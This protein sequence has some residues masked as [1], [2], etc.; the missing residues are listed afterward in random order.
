MDCTH[1]QIFN[2]DISKIT[3]LTY[4]YCSGNLNLTCIQALNSQVKTLWFK[5]ATAEYS[6]NCNYTVGINNETI[7]QPKTIQTI[8]NLQGQQ[9]NTA[10]QG[11]VIIRYTD[12][13]SEKVIQ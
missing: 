9:V 6:E 8:Y 11:I 7:L 1:N 2:L 5:D 4:F 12:G 3:A 13:T 10:Y